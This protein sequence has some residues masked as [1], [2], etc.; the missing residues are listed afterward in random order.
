MKKLPIVL[1]AALAMSSG[2]WVALPGLKEPAGSRLAARTAPSPAAQPTGDAAEKVLFVS[3]PRGPIKGT[4]HI[5][6]P[7]D[8][9]KL[10]WEVPPAYDVGR[11]DA[12][13]GLLPPAAGESKSSFRASCP[14]ASA[15]P[16]CLA[17]SAGQGAARSPA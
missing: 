12:R 8:P 16:V 2:I 7:F 17:S 6:K 14:L 9:W 11:E 10:E 15:G 1:A 13:R 5:A 4:T 3:R